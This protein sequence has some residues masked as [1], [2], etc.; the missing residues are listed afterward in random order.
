[1]VCDASEAAL[2]ARGRISREEAEKLVAGIIADRIARKQFDNCDITMRDLNIIKN[3]IVE[4]HSGVYH[5]RV[6]YPSG[7]F[8][9]I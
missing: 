5:E 9:K 3:T 6:Q 8:K 7:V 1:M 2:R 4:Q